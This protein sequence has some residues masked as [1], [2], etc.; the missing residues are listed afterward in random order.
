MKIENENE[1]ENENDFVDNNLNRLSERMN[2]HRLFS[3]D[4]DAGGWVFCNSNGWRERPVWSLHRLRNM[5]LWLKALLAESEYCQH[6]NIMFNL[7]FNLLH[8]HNR[9][10][11][12]NRRK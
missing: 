12:F 3:N 10:V 2:D 5:T 7:S 1:N 9:E 4:D 6:L 8:N 11:P